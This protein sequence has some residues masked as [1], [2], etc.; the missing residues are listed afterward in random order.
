[1][2]QAMKTILLISGVAALLT[3]CHTPERV[4]RNDATGQTVTCGGNYTLTYEGYQTWREDDERCKQSFRNQ[5]FG[6]ID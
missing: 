6:D 4:L 2:T 1:M 3:G 5:G